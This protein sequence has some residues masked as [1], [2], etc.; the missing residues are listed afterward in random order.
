MNANHPAALAGRVPKEAVFYGDAV[1]A[2]RFA[3]YQ[4]AFT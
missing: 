3:T 1:D 4:G 2:K